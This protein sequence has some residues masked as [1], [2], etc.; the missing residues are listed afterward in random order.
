MTGG[1]LFRWGNFFFLYKMRGGVEELPINEIEAVA[2][3]EEEEAGGG[4][5]YEIDAWIDEMFDQYETDDEIDSNCAFVA[6][7]EGEYFIALDIDDY[8]EFILEQQEPFSI[9]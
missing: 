7:H 2:F 3:E 1:N 6:E 4:E 5:P 9:R 8:N